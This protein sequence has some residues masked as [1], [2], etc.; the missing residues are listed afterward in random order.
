MIKIKAKIKLYRRN[1]YRQLPIS[2]GYKPLFNFIPG[3]KTFGQILLTNCENLFPGMETTAEIIFAFRE[4]LGNNFKVGTKFT[5][6]EGVND[7][8]E[9]IVLEILQE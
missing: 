9:G 1:L 7:V 3:M 5:F 8:G 4:F 6:G 2:N